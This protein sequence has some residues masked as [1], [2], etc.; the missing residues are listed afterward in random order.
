MPKH[1]LA[2]P[3]QY[4]YQLCSLCG[5]W[6]VTHRLTRGDLFPSINAAIHPR[7]VTHHPTLD[8]VVSK[9]PG[10]AVLLLP[11][12]LILHSD[13]CADKAQPHGKQTQLQGERAAA[14][15]RMQVLLPHR[16]R[17]Q[18]EDQPCDG[19][20]LRGGAI[21]NCAH[22]RRVGNGH[23]DCYGRHSLLHR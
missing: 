14:G 18:P 23:Y 17:R 3:K 13:Q 10:Q 21:T 5:G 20:D 11:I 12:P 22:D 4:T 15:L 2:P 1:A 8:K 7:R 19:H 9:Q 16:V 6:Q